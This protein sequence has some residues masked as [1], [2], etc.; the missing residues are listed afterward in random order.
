MA[1]AGIE[2][3]GIGD[4][5]TD[6]NDP[7]P[8]PPISVEEPTVRMTFAVN[9]SPFAGREGQYLT[10]RQMRARLFDELERN[11]AMR[12]QETERANEFIVSGRGELHLAIL[13]ETMRRE[14]F[15]FAVSRPEV[16]FRDEPEGR[17]EPMEKVYVEVAEEF[18]GAVQEMLGRRRAL[19]QN[20]RYGEDGTVYCTYLVPT[21]GMLGFRQPFLTSTRGTGIYH[22]LFHGYEPYTGDIDLQEHGTLVALETG[23]VSN[24]ALINLQ[25]RGAFFVRAGE[26]VYAGQVVG[27]NIRDEE[28]VINVCRTKQLT[29]FREK[30]SGLTELLAPPRDLSLD[31]AIEYLANDDLLEVTPMSLRIRKK[32]LNH[33]LRARARRA[34]REA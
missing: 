23:T 25:Q 2:G 14:G 32:M 27:K 20:I 9:D 17:Q 28:L 30:P 33:D 16:I 26:E 5:L 31:D 19:M 22:T 8:L 15:E 11:V 12:V 18:L 34:Q 21:R 7:R 10:S 4:T 3:V 1:V 29:N 24:Y 6:P 13:I